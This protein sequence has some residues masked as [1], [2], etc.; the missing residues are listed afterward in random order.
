MREKLRVPEAFERGKS[1]INI[2][3]LIRAF[4]AELSASANA[5]AAGPPVSSKFAA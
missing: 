1:L 5:D 2:N 4:R 3:G